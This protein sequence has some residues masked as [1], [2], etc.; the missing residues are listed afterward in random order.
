VPNVRDGTSRYE[1]D[2]YH[3]C[4]F[5]AVLRSVRQCDEHRP[6]CVNCLTAS[7]SCA[8]LGQEQARLASAEA[9]GLEGIVLSESGISTHNISNHVDEGRRTPNPR[10][11]RPLSPQ[12]L[13]P[14]STA[15]D[16]NLNMDHMELLHH[17]C[18][19]TFETLTPEPAQQE[20]WQ[21]T[22]IKLGF[23]F[24]F[25]MH[26][27]LAIAALH[28]AHCRPERQDHYYTKAT[29]LQNH[30]LNG[31]NAIRENVGASNCEAIMLFASLLALHVL[32]DPSRSRG[33][34]SSEYLDHFLGCINLMR[35]VRNVV[36]SDWWS[37]LSES[38]LKPLLQVKQPEQ[39][40][41]IPDECRELAQLTR[42]ADLSTASIEAYDAAIERLHRSFAVS[43][44]PLQTH[45]T[46]R[47]L[48]AWPVQLKDGFLELLNERRP[49]ALIILAYYG[50]LLHFYR[51]SWAVGDSGTFL[52]RSINAHTGAY[53]GRWM[54]WPNRMIQL[55]GSAS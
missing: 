23:S 31:F 32:A 52:V 2:V 33:L 46:I 16:P 45:S 48:L 15:T 7:L 55:S 49:E 25:L 28:L 5:W 14:P 37:Y 11:R 17:F 18:M 26:E 8:F 29:E 4:R 38:D 53:W 3:A 40:Y 42:N 35:G 44:V 24:P 1:W 10:L 12:R 43:N 30:A 34:N 13:F 36:I 20:V 27:I 39:P 51:D 54:A 6:V 21:S 19:V 9:T 22:A 50:V 41:N 47:W